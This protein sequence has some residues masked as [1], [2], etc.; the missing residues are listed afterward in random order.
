MQLFQH[1][2]IVNYT[3]NILD[4]VF[5]NDFSIEI[6]ECSFP[7]VPIDIA[8]PPLQINGLN[9]TTF[10]RLKSVSPDFNFNKT[11][12]EAMNKYFNNIDWKSLLSDSLDFSLVI[13]NFYSTIYEAITI[14]TP[15]FAK[16]NHKYT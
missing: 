6:T 5:S 2:F 13:S 9:N 12:Y 3:N 11:N 7:L 15:K 14:C 4:L 16:C 1:N 10:C 8:H